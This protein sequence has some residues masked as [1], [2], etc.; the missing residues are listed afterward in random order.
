MTPIQ[1]IPASSHLAKID[2]LRTKAVQLEAFLFE[3]MLQ[4]S[5]AGTPSIA[6]PTE[7]Q[8]ESFLRRE[9]AEAV[10]GSART[11]LAEAIYLS[12][13]RSEAGSS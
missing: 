3:T 4:A 6:G 1:P 9:R 7:S 10:A 13:K 2:P 8:F 11:G 5:G 12:L